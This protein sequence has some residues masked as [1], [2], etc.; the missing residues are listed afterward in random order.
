MIVLRTGFYVVLLLG[1]GMGLAHLFDIPLMLASWAS[2][3]ALIAGFRASPAARPV[4]VAAGHLISGAVGYGAAL[5]VPHLGAHA[6]W[7]A[8]VAA[9]IAAMAMMTLQFYHPPAAANAVIPLFTTVALPHFAAALAVG[10]L[11]LGTVA[12]LLD[13]RDAAGAVP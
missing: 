9:A 6:L 4:P 8:P 7:I 12:W 13:R 5:L 10:A 3:A 2:S 11:A 1:A